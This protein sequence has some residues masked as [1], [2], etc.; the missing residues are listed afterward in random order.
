MKAG[1]SVCLCLLLAVCLSALACAGMFRNYGRINPSDEV[2]NAFATFQVNKDYRYYISGPD[3]NPTALMG[4]DKSYRLDPETTWREVQMTP[5]RMK[6][7]VE[8]MDTKAG[9]QHES[10]RGFQLLDNSGR[11]IGVWYSLIRARTFVLMRDNGTVRIDS[12]DLDTYERKA[13][14]ILTDTEK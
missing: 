13:G 10:Q 7:L 4:L 12:P 6:E 3:L 1:R 8:G 9:M 11:P 5:E 14:S 2:S